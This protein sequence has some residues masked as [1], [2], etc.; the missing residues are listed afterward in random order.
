M[1]ILAPCIAFG[2]AG[3]APNSMAEPA[4]VPREHCH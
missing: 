4:L 2:T 1:G 3:I